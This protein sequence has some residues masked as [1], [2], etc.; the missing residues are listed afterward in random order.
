MIALYIKE[1]LY[2]FVSLEQN[3][4]ATELTSVGVV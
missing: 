1:I 3:R 4:L 2:I